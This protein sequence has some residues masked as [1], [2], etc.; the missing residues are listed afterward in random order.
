MFDF[1]YVKE[2]YFL[3]CVDEFMYLELVFFEKLILVI[4]IKYEY[5]G[6]VVG[7]GKLFVLSWV[8]VLFVQIEVVINWVSIWVKYVKV[9]F[10]EIILKEILSFLEFLSQL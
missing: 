4:L 1:V 7:F 8:C 2:N 6:S 10:D 5:I 3:V 9:D